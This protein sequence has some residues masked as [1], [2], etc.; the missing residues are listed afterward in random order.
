[1]SADEQNQRCGLIVDRL[2]MPSDPR[3]RISSLHHGAEETRTTKAVVR[4]TRSR[5]N[6]ETPVLNPQCCAER[7]G[8]HASPLNCRSLR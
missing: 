6:V 7:V 4:A 3:A 8:H 1:M 2:R 5:E